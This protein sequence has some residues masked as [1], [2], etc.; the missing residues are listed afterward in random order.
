MNARML[1]VITGVIS[2]AIFIVLLILLPVGFQSANIPGGSGLAYIVAIAVY[3][4]F[5]SGSGILI[6]EKIA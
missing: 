6:R 2:L 5:M 3:I 4:A 1:D